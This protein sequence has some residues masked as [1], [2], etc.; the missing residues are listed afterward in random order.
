MQRLFD[1]FEKAAELIGKLV[2]FQETNRCKQILQRGITGGIVIN[3]ELSQRI[4]PG[5]TSVIYT[6]E[7][8]PTARKQ[9]SIF[10]ADDLKSCDGRLPTDRAP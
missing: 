1:D 9:R 6:V 10:L 7:F 5:Q 2:C 8:G 3:V 4:K